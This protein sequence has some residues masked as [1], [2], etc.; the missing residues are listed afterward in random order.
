[1]KKYDFSKINDSD[2]SFSNL[3]V[4]YVLCD[5]IIKKRMTSDAR[6]CLF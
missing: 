5:Q 1:M 6:C 4:V 2:S 3:V